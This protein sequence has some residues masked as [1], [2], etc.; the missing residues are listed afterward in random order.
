MLLDKHIA[1]LVLDNAHQAWCKGDLAGLLACYVDDL[2]YQ[3]NVGPA[4]KPLTINGKAELAAM[5]GPVMEVAD[6]KSVIDYF[7]LE[8]GV[9]RARVSSFV[10]HRSTGLTI[11]G[12]YRQVV[13]YRGCLICRLEEFHDAARLAAFWR[14]VAAESDVAAMSEE[15]T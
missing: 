6:S 5:L 15:A 13:E 4:G 11:S 2:V 9:G 10:R 1:R 3:C 8:D 12:I 7:R 14:M